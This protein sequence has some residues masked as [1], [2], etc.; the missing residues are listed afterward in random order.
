MVTQSASSYPARLDIE[1]VT[2]ARHI[3]STRR[4][5]AC[6][7]REFPAVPGGKPID[8]RKRA[9]GPALT[10]PID[11]EPAEAVVAIG[12]LGL[13]RNAIRMGAPSVGR[14]KRLV[15]RPLFRP[16]ADIMASIRIHLEIDRRAAAPEHVDERRH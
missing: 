11:H 7:E 5:A 8:V 3:N 16:P 2:P 10:E 9:I 6:E 13:P 12:A 1:G 4:T 14:E 15:T